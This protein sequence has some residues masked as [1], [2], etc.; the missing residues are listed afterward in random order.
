M[1]I[2]LCLIAFFL[3]LIDLDL[4]NVYSSLDRIANNLSR[5]VDYLKATENELHKIEKQ[6]GKEADNADINRT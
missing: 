4:S 1:T 2:A 5:S 6:M 3:L